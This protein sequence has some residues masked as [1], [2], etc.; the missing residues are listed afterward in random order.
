DENDSYDYEKGAYA[1]FT[2]SW[3]DKNHSLTISDTQ[4][5][6]PGMLKK[7]TFNVVLVNEQQGTNLKVTAKANKV[8]QYEGKR[9]NIKL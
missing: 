8:V 4:G 6:F 9:V 3:D 2:L 5:K 1:T 7:H